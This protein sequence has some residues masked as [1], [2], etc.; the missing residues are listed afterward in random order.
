MFSQQVSES[1]NL[2]T[3]AALTPAPRLV[4]SP[5]GPS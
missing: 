2:A 3:G 1:I 4:Q 5:I